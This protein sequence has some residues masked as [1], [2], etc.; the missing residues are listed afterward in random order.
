MH[1]PETHKVKRSVPKRPG[2]TS[3]ELYEQVK[4]MAILYTVR[5]G[6]RV[7]EMELAAQFEVSRTPLREALNRLVAENILDFVPNRG[8]FVR[9]LNRQAVFDLYELRRS[10]ESSAVQL[11]A[12]RAS[13]RDIKA[14]RK[15]WKE[16][17]R[18]K[19]SI[20]PASELVARDEAFHVRLVA[21][22][23]NKEMVRALENVNARIH[24]VRWVDFEQ[25]GDDTFS[26][27]FEIL[28]AVEARD[29][30]KCRELIE[31]HI[32]CRMEE[33]A[34]VVDAGIVKLYSR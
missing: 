17:A 27:H 8:F 4:E 12:E 24:F 34:K 3:N 16:A 14:L 31:A 9:E 22:S 13:E 25:R 29:I 15:F 30:E 23:G 5:P 1:A 19:A 2:L 7:N 6:E 28:D 33:I 10:L 18:T 32:T 20:A 26:E 11:A 21:L